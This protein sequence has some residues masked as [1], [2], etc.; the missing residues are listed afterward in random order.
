MKGRPGD[1]WPKVI[2]RAVLALLPGVELA[3]VHVGFRNIPRIVGNPCVGVQ[4]GAARIDAVVVG[5]VIGDN[6]RRD[7]VPDANDRGTFAFEHGQRGAAEAHDPFEGGQRVGP[8]AGAERSGEEGVD[9]GGRRFGQGHVD[10]VEA[11]GHR[12]L[13][14]RGSRVD[15]VRG[16]W[17]GLTV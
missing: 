12:R 15:A 13:C 5:T 14:A 8:F 7:I 17:L 11:N 1:V 9:G 16:G 3:A 6:G 2:A 4:E 10:P